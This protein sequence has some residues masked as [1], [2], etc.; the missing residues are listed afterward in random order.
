VSGTLSM[1]QNKFV[2]LKACGH[3]LSAKAM[4]NVDSGGPADGAS[5]SGW[6]CP[7]CSHPNQTSLPLFPSPEALGPLREALHRK[8]GKSK[9][10]QE[11]ADRGA[12]KA[13]KSDSGSGATH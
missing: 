13:A 2:V 10:K 9:R 12:T 3:V 1:G 5:D 8:R 11:G 6:D 4:H 7:V